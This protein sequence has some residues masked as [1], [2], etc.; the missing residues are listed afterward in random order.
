MKPA[1]GRAFGAQ[2]AGK[3][4][5]AEIVGIV[6]LYA[7]FAAL[8]ILLSDE[9]IGL[10]FSDP[11]T[12]VLASTLKGLGFVAVTSLLL[13]ILLRRLAARTDAASAASFVAA[14]F[15]SA[16]D[17]GERRGL[18][19]G[20]LVLSAII[21]LAGTGAV[22]HTAGKLKEHEVARL[23]SIA[24]LKADQ[25][26]DWLADRRRDAEVLRTSPNFNEILAR[27]RTSR[28]ADSRARILKRMEGFHRAMGYPSMLLVD[29][30]GEPLLAVGETGHPVTALLREVVSR[31]LTSGKMQMTDIY[32]PLGAQNHVDLDFIVPLDSIAGQPRFAVVVRVDPKAFLFRYLQIWPVPSDTAE[33]LLFRRDGDHVLFLNDLRHRP[34]SALRLRLPLNQRELLAA[35]VA[36]GRVPSGA[37]VEGVDYRSV[38]ALGVARAIAGT[39]WYLIAKMDKAELYA[40]LGKD[41]AWIVLA[42]ALA[43][44]AA[45]A[46]GFLLHLRRELHWAALRHLEQSQKLS[47][48]QLLD[49]IVESSP[50]AIFAKDVEGRFLLANA[51]VARVVGKPVAEILGHDNRAIFPPDIAAKTMADDRRVMAAGRAE[52]YEEAVIGTNGMRTVLITKGPLHDAAGKVVGTF[53]IA[54]DISERRLADDA[55]R[56]SE[57]TYRALFDNM[58]N[59]FAYCRMLFEDG[60]P[61]DFIYLSVNQAF[62]KLTGLQDVIGRKVSEVIPGIR[63]RDPG[64]IES[65]GRVAVSGE[66]EHFEVYVAALEMWFSISVYSP[67]KEHFVAVFDV[68]TERKQAELQLESERTHLH[69]LVQT[70]PDLVWLKDA[71]GVY[72]ASNPEFERFFGAREA[73]IL[74]KTDYDFVDKE[75][76]DFFRQ[77]DKEAMAAGKPSRNEEWITYASDGH[78]ALLETIKTPMRSAT[79]ELIGVLGIGRDITARRAAEDE[80]RKLSLAVEQSPETIII[81]D[82]DGNIEYVNAAGLAATGY[83]REEMIGQNPRLLQ[84]GQTPQAS[85]DQLWAAL[86]AGETWQGEFINQRKDGGIY[87]EFVRVSPVRQPDGRIT[88]YLA[89]KED[90]SERKRMGAELDRHRH[91]LEELV[92]ERTAQLAIARDAAEA[93]SRAKGAFVANISHEIRTPMNA[94][95]GFTHL[96]QRQSR[97]PEQQDKLHKIADAAHHLLA[98]INDILD[99]SKI[100]AGKLAIEPRDFEL[101]RIFD[102]VRSLVLEKAQAKGLELAVELDPAL[103]GMLNG[104][105]TR[106]AQALLN[107]AANAVK[108]TERGRIV[109]G[110]TL[111]EESAGELK[112]RFSVQDTGIGI[113]PEVQARLFGEFEQADRSTTRQYGGTGLGLAITRRLAELMGGDIGLSSQPGVGSTFTFFVRLARGTHSASRPAD[114]LSALAPPTPLDWTLAQN[115][116]DLRLLL[117]EDNP[118]NREVAVELL[119]ESGCH[120][121]L[122]ENGVEAVA[123]VER[124]R[125]DLILMDVHMPEMDG[126]EA[127]RAIRKLPGGELV[128]II[129]MTASAYDDD[130]QKCLAAGMNDHVA[131]PVDPDNLFATM[132]K[133]L[134]KQEVAAAAPAAGEAE[135]PEQA[136][137]VVPADIPGL[138][139]AFGLRTV[140][141]RVASYLRLLRLFAATHAED[142]AKLRLQLGAGDIDAALLIAHSLRGAAGMLG[143]TGVQARAAE[144]EAALRSRETAAALEEKTAALEAELGPLLT[145]LTI[146]LPVEEGA[147]AHAA[148]PA[149]VAEV[150]ERLERLLAEDNIEAGSVF[151]QSAPLLRAALGMATEELAW[152][153]SRFDYPAALARLRALR[154]LPSPKNA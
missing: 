106:L 143:A 118:L 96:L 147:V 77:K 10:V 107:Y 131:K 25:I 146:Q 122:A 43:S 86:V 14:D 140:R 152:A 42:G 4:A 80:L 55:L 62:G 44:F 39:P 12:L 45:L 138:D 98:I 28:D 51:G 88:H 59:G 78:R 48:L 125:Y 91:H 87:T 99:L 65:Y 135:A 34:D 154:A 15:R 130:R 67:G 75:L 70:I 119:R 24:N 63:E 31:A 11:N 148:G 81:T 101:N 114:D 79:G 72:L 111:L 124:G 132:M 150:L 27:W 46:G 16:A 151:R 95:I 23:Q 40:G 37:M 89:V 133:W 103:A 21:I 82:T 153:I 1:A 22:F 68:I 66:P 33:T 100:E 30:T 2:C 52:T 56:A 116:C 29:A 26:E 127:T 83:T 69:A 109:L 3:A 92:A 120:V 50:D 141:G 5:L 49:T 97:D 123:L 117:A 94:I 74:G 145:A 115:R 102:N 61:S 17:A 137:D 53:G 73:N 84:S 71:E 129:A 93:A 58:L 108:F 20:V 41:A 6:L 113:P 19:V 57:A 18:I 32:R 105:P 13:F 110:A 9:A 76:A 112:V 85:Y 136:A 36:D 149:A 139:T 38:P 128:P 144:L 7:A 134:P 64:L 35:Q 142:M 104:D 90:I 60:K 47:A 121:D 126:L 54:R 8:W